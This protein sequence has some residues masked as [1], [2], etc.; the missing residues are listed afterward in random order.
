[1]CRW[2]GSPLMPHPE[3]GGMFLLAHVTDPHFRGSFAGVRPAEFISKRVLGTLNL[4]VN[5]RRHHKMELLEALRLDMRAQAPDHLA[6]TGDLSNVSLPGEFRAA[7]A[8]LDTSG[9]EPAAITVIPGNHDA[10][11][12]AVVT[13]R[14]FERAF[15]PYMTDDLQGAE[16]GRR[17]D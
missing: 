5:R 1:M 16:A 10:Y 17:A 4:V 6:L 11:V 9:L 7:L 3:R 14:D 8:W 2:W 13:S 15:A 12:E